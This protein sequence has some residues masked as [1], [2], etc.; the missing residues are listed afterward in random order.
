MKQDLHY[1]M[2]VRIMGEE[3]A[4][5]PGVA[6]L[7]KGIEEMGSMQKAAEKMGLSYSKAWKMMKTAEQ[8]LGFA[9]TERSSGGKD[10]GGSVVTEEGREMMQRYGNF[11]S[12]L[13]TEADRLFAF[14]FRGKVRNDAG[15]NCILQRRRMYGKTGGWRIGTGPFP[16]AKTGEKDETCSLALK[17]PTMRRFIGF[18]KI[19][20]LCRHWIFFRQWWKTLIFLDRLQQPMLS[21]T[22]TP[23]A[24]M[25]GQL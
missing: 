4:F 1:D 7:L 18:Q 14:I 19:L 16:S 25:C 21:V 13:Q 22:F 17:A 10:G 6:Q 5:G 20:P 23:W 15:R 3:K 12:A 24:A 11:L 8:E 2:K 9:L